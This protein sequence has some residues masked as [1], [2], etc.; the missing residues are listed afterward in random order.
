MLSVSFNMPVQTRHGQ[1][2]KMYLMFQLVKRI[3]VNE[4]IINQHELWKFFN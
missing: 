4:I 2:Y 1:V 3:E